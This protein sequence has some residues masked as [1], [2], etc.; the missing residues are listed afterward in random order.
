MAEGPFPQDE[1]ERDLPREL[2][3][4]GRPRPGPGREGPAERRGHLPRRDQPDAAPVGEPAVVLR[5]V[6]EVLGVWAAQGVHCAPPRVPQQP[7]R[8]DEDGRREEDRNL[9]RV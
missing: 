3:D 5:Q 9:Q 8:H 6:A 4:E 7:H 1:A 2:H